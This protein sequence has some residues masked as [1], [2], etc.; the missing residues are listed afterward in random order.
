MSNVR[1]GVQLYS[2]QCTVEELR[3]AWRLADEAG[4]DSMWLWDHFFAGG[5]DPDQRHYEAWTLLSAMACDTSR[6]QI[7]VLVSG[8][9]YRNPDLLADMARTVDHLAGGRAVLGIGAGWNEY[10]YNEYGYEFGTAADRL[11]ALEE[12][13]K[14]IKHR[15]SKL[16]PPPLGSLPI[17]I[18]GEGE[19]VTLRLRMERFRPCRAVRPQEQCARRM[20]RPRRSRSQGNRTERAVDEGGRRGAGGRVRGARGYASDRTRPASR[21]SGE[22][23]T[24]PRPRPVG[25]KGDTP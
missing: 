6:A 16:D 22:P 3:A 24:G 19:K 20:V 8:N 7:G 23:A 12:G 14:R 2:K 21:L 15:L 11:R 5:D 18:G 13:L 9:S 10:E 1:V 17:L 25:L 4:I